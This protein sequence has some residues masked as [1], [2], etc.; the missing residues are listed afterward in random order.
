M[1]N[2]YVLGVDL[3][4]TKIAAAVFDEYH[5]RIADVHALPTMANQP[6]KLTLLNLKRVITKAIRATERDVP[7]VAVGL[8]SPGRLD[9]STGSIVA[10]N[11]PHLKKFPLMHRLSE[12]LEVPIFWENDANCF[13]LAEALMGAGAGHAIVLGLTLGTGF[14]CG[15][16]FDG[17]LYHGATG[18]AGE[19][20]HC[21]I[22]GRRFDE[23]LSG[24]GVR[25]FYEYVISGKHTAKVADSTPPAKE[26][27]EMAENGDPTALKAWALFGQA[28]GDAIGIISSVIDP[29]ICVVGGS[30]ATRFDLFRPT[31]ELAFNASMASGVPEGPLRIE[32]SHLKNAAGVVGAAEHAFACLVNQKESNTS[33]SE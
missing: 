33:Q 20:A 11:L 13:T 23:M 32:P 7:L 21:R 31:L 16:T 10:D 2:S 8:G 4:G 29:T 14:G 17:Q 30:V 28:L 15:V 5:H 6:V 1:S 24:D 26:I 25:R 9:E 18:T 22:A 19:L 12:E 3:G 27:G